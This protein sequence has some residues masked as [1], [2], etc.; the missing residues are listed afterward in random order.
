VQQT[1]WGAGTG[2]IDNPYRVGLPSARSGVG[3]VDGPAARCPAP[4]VGLSTGPVDGRAIITPAGAS[5]MPPSHGLEGA[6]RDG[7][8]GP[9]A[10]GVEYIV[11]LRCGGFDQC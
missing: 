3:D 6:G 2:L 5:A 1:R 4:G 11:N 8:D 10:G 7:E 9:A